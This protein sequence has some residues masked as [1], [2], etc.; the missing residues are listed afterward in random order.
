VDRENFSNYQ[1]LAE[2]QTPKVHDSDFIANHFNIAIAEPYVIICY[3]LFS[4]AVHGGCL[5]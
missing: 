2:Q 3:F 1:N 5:C 4:F